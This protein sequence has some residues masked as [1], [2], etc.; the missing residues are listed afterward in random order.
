MKSATFSSSTPGSYTISV[1]SVT[2]GK[3]GSLWE[4]A[5]AEFM[6]IVN[7]EPTPTPVPDTTPPE[8]SYTISGTEG[9]NGW[10]VSNVSVEW[11]VTDPESEVTIDEGC[12]D[13]TID[14]DT[15]GVTL[16]CTASSA[17]GTSSQSVTIKRDATAPTITGSRSPDPNAN[18]WNNTDV[19]VSFTC[20]DNLSG[21]ASCS[22]P[23]TLS[24]E[25][26]GQSVTGTAVDNAGNSATATVSG[27]NIDKT[28]PT[29]TITTPADG[30][31]YTLNQSVAASY[32]C[33]DSLSGVA[34]CTG[35][36]PNGSNIDTST[37]GSKTF[38]VNA[39]DN[40][41][42]TAT[43]THSYRVIYSWAGF[44][45]PVDNPP[46]VNVAKAGSAIPVKFSLSGFQGM[47][48][49]A[50]GY[51]RAVQTNCSSGELTDVIDETVT[52]GGSSLN[53]DP[54]VDQYIYVWKTDKAWA[55]QCRQLQVQL[56]DG[57]LHVANFRFTK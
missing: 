48:I 34:S 33:S 55:G 41:G 10:Y 9:S 57:T 50:S 27:I 7:P 26:A 5:P 42:N 51:P 45:R 40:A 16:I 44:F 18:G 12:E 43:K 31:T 24:D 13:T 46:I 54:L 38:T 1:A 3:D 8:I 2:G 52:A 35:P 21:V 23:V 17:G 14:S 37:V 36:V 53:Y 4:T 6:L 25:G 11:T 30:A 47:N 15:G 22:G 19:T 20:D 29:I 32:S 56:V 28:A 49:F 39:T